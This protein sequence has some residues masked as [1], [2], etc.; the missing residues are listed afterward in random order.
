MMDQTMTTPVQTQARLTSFLV[1]AG[2][3]NE[4]QVKA[5]LVHQRITGARIGETLVELGVATEEDI[6]W[7]LARQLSIPFIDV[8]LDMLDRELIGRFPPSLL[9]RL[10][11]VPLIR[12]DGTL[13]TAMA[14]PT[15]ADAVASLE[16][17]T[18]ARI[19]ISVATPSTILR[20]LREVCPIPANGPQP[21]SRSGA[22][23]L[24]S[25]LAGALEA[26]ASEVHW[27]AGPEGVQVSR[28]IGGRLVPWT[29]EPA[30]LL[31]PLLNRLEAL[32]LPAPTSSG[33]NHRAGRIQIPIDGRDVG[34]EISVLIH[35]RGTAIR[36]RPL[37]SERCPRTLSELGIDPQGEQAIRAALAQ[38]SG[39]VILNSQPGAGASTT[40]SCLMGA[41]SGSNRRVLALA[42]AASS[43]WLEPPPSTLLVTVPSKVSAGYWE[44]I[45]IG[46]DPEVVVFGDLTSG[47]DIALALTPALAGRV[48]L[49]RTDWEDPFALLEF[50]GSVPRTRAAACARLGI[51]IEQRRLPVSLETDRGP[52]RSTATPRYA[53]DTLTM[54]SR[55]REVLRSGAS[56][57]ELHH[58]AARDGYR[59]P[60]PMVNE[61]IDAEWADRIDVHRSS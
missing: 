56:A 31:T 7:A 4:E 25:Q 50:L 9:D 15:D 26:G 32:G 36:L 34:A 45:V 38:R 8:Q 49:A 19:A 10:Q 48:V 2:T 24:A 61:T 42:S 37:S 60:N 22:A 20:V 12:T 47:D 46:Q 40:L 53:I 11:A 6:A 17:Y 28:R 41:A 43:G 21:N 13:S 3:I 16:H 51:V 5:A 23:F 44:D 52:V 14:D 18:G 59:G 27:M 57:A 1:D 33:A 54:T 30:N 29:M 39:L 55:L 58:I 35:D